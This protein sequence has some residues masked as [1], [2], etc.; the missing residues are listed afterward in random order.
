MG[1]TDNKWVKKHSMIPGN[2]IWRKNTRNG[3]GWMGR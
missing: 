1:V 3:G 2:D